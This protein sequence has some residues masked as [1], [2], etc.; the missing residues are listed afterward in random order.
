MTCYLNGH[1]WDCYTGTLSLSQVTPIHLKMGYQKRTSTGTHSSN[2]WQRLERMVGYQWSSPVVTNR[3]CTTFLSMWTW[4]RHQMETFSAL[5]AICAGNSLVSGEFPT[6]RPVSQS[7]DVFF[8]LRLNKRLSKQSWAWWFERPLCSLWCH[9][10]EIKHCL[11][12]TTQACLL[13]KHGGPFIYCLINYFM[14]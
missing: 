11:A 8:Y 13:Q 14:N 5:L 9:C 1:S 2:E 3:L 7:F 6:Q 12:I 4:W 10:N